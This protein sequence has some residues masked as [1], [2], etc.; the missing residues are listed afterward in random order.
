MSATSQNSELLKMQKLREDEAVAVG[1]GEFLSGLRDLPDSL[2]PPGAAKLKLGSGD[3][4][5]K[6]L[7]IK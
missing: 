1:A 2:A 4:K 3:L 6:S 5:A 7:R